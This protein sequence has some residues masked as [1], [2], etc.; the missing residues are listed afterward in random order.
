M[1]GHAGNPASRSNAALCLASISHPL[2]QLENVISD[3]LSVATP[4][5][6][7]GEA[8]DRHKEEKAREPPSKALQSLEQ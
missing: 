4:S 5:D 8:D 3:A 7:I 6:A 1:P 2:R